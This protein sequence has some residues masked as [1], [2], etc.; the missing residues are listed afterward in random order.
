MLNS[1]LADEYR[2]ARLNPGPEL[3]GLRQAPFDEMRKKVDTKTAIDLTRLYFGLPVPGGTDWFR[4]AFR[5]SDASF[6]MVDN[7]REVA[8]LAASLLHGALVDG[9]VYA[10]LAVLGAAASGQRQPQVNP[11][12]PSQAEATIARISK[13]S[14]ERAAVSVANIRVPTPSKMPAQVAAFAPTPDWAKTGAL[15]ELASAEALEWTKTLATQVASVLNPVSAEV[16]DLREETAM[17]WW[18]IG[19]WSRLLER[20]FLDLDQSLAAVLVG[21][22]LAELSRTP[23]GPVAAPELLWRTLSRGRVDSTAK[24]SLKT[25]VDA[26]LKEKVSDKLK[27]GERLKDA[28]ETCPVLTALFKASEVG[29]AW[30]TPFKTATGGLSAEWEL[31]PLALA[32]QVYRERLLLKALN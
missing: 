3:L 11:E 5:A 26:F 20:P 15:W 8:V 10:G 17:L 31:T 22:D 12:F 4:D 6:S 28:A 27:F 16:A 19:S 9:K 24:V 23:Q 7:A 29:D 32:K 2:A 14:R 1:N 18:H 30:P 21:V 13:S 25:A